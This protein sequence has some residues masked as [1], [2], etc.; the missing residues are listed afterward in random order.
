MMMNRAGMW[1]PGLT[2]T[3]AVLSVGCHRPPAH[4]GA[5][6]QGMDTAFAAMQARGAIVM[7]VDQY[8]SQH[9]FQDLPDGGRIVLENDDGTDTAAIGRIRAHMRDIATV[10]G[11]GDFTKPLEVHGVTVPGT[12]VM[13]ARRAAITYEEV[14]RPRGAEVRIRTADTVAVGAVHSFLAFQRE[15][16]HPSGH[17][18]MTGHMP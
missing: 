6:A 12:D 14:D 3:V 2:V 15:A 5:V 17:G 7:G 1:S 13:T 8:T 11:R 10:F 16:H 4:K 9:V 18:G